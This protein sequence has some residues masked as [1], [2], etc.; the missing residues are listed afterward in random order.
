MKDCI[1]C[2]I[3]KREIPSGIIYEDETHISFL[4]INPT[5]EG[6]TVV[7][8]KKHHDS[9]LYSNDTAVICAIMSAAKN[10]AGLL[11]ERLG[12]ERVLT[13][14]EG[15]EI[16]HLHVKLYPYY[17]NR[18]AADTLTEHIGQ[19]PTKEYLKNLAERIGFLKI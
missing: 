13:A 18:S 10:T 9:D 17:G 6:M 3:A 4:D 12:C 16:D 5:T 2:K 19:K 15:L 14:V 7:I 8:T 1:F 11:K